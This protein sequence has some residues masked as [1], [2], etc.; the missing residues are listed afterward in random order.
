[1]SVVVPFRAMRPQKK[2]AQVVASLPYDVMSLEEAKAMAQNNPLSFLHVERSE[3][4]LPAEGDGSPYPLAARNLQKMI[5]DG[6]LFQD[7]KPCFYV[8][9]QK[10][11]SHE[12]YGIVAGISVAEYEAGRIKKHELTKADKEKDRT[13]H[14]ST[15]NAHT[16]P[17]FVAYKSMADIDKIV[18]K[19]VAGPREYDFVSDDGILH[20]AWVIAEDEDIDTL[21]SLFAGV[22]NLY[23]ADGHHR[24]AAAAAV[25]RMKTQKNPTHQG[26]ENY[27]FML[28][29]LFPD[30]QLRIMEYNR[31]VKDLHG[32]D[33]AAFLKRVE[34]KFNIISLSSEKLPRKLHDFD[35][36]LRD[37]WYRIAPKKG[38]F[39]A[40]DP[41]RH[42]DVYILQKNLLAPIL[43]I[44][45][46]R[47]DRRIDYV[48]GV[49]G[50]A[51]LERLV[52]S[53]DYAVAFS[54]FPTTMEQLFAVADAGLIMPPKST[55]F[56]PK[57]RSGLFVHMF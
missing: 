30:N 52:H 9:R 55:W 25:A 22:E 5:S 50:A 34:K 45:N 16:G 37:R 46:P 28:A 29:V 39:D 42:L 49:R 1:M 11:G 32:L 44:K 43:G 4:D 27:N 6:V 31:V 19:V 14:V 23:I 3:I 47:T 15:V 18:A 17:V 10:M 12:Q 57:L 35:M 51:E 26:N 38:T 21:I 33:E 53:G 8:Y 41:V 24:A 36:Y 40:D 48:G 7:E 13:D 2:L 20:T 54:L 56:E